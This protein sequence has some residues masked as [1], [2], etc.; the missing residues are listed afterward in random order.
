MIDLSLVDS[1]K[2]PDLTKNHIHK[3]PRVHVSI[4]RSQMAVGKKRKHAAEVKSQ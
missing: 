3:F 1:T 2:T 4:Q